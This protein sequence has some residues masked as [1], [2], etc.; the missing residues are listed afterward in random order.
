[1]SPSSIWQEGSTDGLLKHNTIYKT[2]L[3]YQD[4]LLHEP[5][6]HYLMHYHMDKE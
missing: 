3:S 2:Y 6:I 4:V 5:G 1:M